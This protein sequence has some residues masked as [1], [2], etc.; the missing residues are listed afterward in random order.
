MPLNEN[1]KTEFKESFNH[2]DFEAEVVSFLNEEGGTIYIGV[3]NKGVGKGV[4]DIDKT[5]LLASDSLLDR[6]AP[7]CS[8][9]T[10][11]HED[12]VDGAKVVRVDVKKGYRLFHIKKYGHSPKGCYRRYGSRKKS[13]TQDEIDRRYR[14][15]LPQES[16]LEKKSPRKELTFSV[17]KI[18]LNSAKVAFQDASFGEDFNLRRE[19]GA[20]NY[21]AYLLSDQFDESIK[22]AR[23]KGKGESGDLVM[24][25]EFGKGCIFKVF[26]DLKDYMDSVERRVRTYFDNGMRRDEY[27]YDEEAFTEAWKNA[28]LHNSYHTGQFPQIY[29][30]D[31]HLE[32][33]SHGNPLDRMGK[34]EFLRGKSKPLNEAL[35]KIA[36]NVELTDQTGKGNKDIVR[37]YGPEAFEFSDTFLTVKLPYNP[38]A[39]DGNEGTGEMDVPVNVPVNA[40]AL[41]ESETAVLSAL[42]TNPNLVRE[43]L[44]EVLGKS[45]KTVARALDSLKKKGRI[46]RVGADKNG[47]WEIA[48]GNDN[49]E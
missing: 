21:M 20:Y 16:I 25:K 26:Y 33:M 39:M 48:G 29:L 35:M 11:I 4:A 23:F 27:L 19:N 8:E 46:V 30:Y 1:E 3:T 5:M 6:I 9:L 38:L 12:E 42:A 36:I 28:I 32:I 7:D 14:A 31:D 10:S 44:A 22:V 49:G 40:D 41:N 2:E 47:H 37:A 15:S 24:R 17:L 13:M 45:V 43:Q 18:Y 34:D